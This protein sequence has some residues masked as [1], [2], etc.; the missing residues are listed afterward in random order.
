MR[1]SATIV[2]LIAKVDAPLTFNGMF[3]ERL[4]LSK[5]LKVLFVHFISLFG[6]FFEAVDSFCSSSVF[7]PEGS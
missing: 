7:P 4:E 5:C 6:H 3:F 1:Y 2:S